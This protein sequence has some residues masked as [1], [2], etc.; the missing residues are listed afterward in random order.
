MNSHLLVHALYT[1]AIGLGLNQN[2]KLGTQFRSATWVIG[3][4]LLEH[5]LLPEV[6]R[7]AEL[8]SKPGTLMWDMS[9]LG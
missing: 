4:L 7:D 3:S 8:E 5:L 9:L 6:C 2:Q 1:L